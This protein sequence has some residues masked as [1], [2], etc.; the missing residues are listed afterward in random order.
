M[1]TIPPLEELRQRYA[2]VMADEAITRMSAWIEPNADGPC[3]DEEYLGRI[4]G[5][6]DIL[7]DKIEQALALGE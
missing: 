2:G 3:D 7:Q 1:P 6:F 5:N 4:M